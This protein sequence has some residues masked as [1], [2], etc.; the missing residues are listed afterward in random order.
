MLRKLRLPLCVL[1]LGAFFFAGGAAAQGNFE[2]QVYDS[3]TVAPGKLM[4]ELHSN[5]AVRGTTQKTEGVLPTQHALH[6]TLEMT[7][8]L[9]SWFET[10]FYFFASVQPGMAW[11]WVG[12]HV[13]PKIRVPENWDWPVGVALSAEFGYQQRKFSTDTWTVEIRPIIDKKIGRWYLALN[14]VLGRSLKGENAKRGLDFN[15]SLKVSYD[16]TSKITG[17]I[18]YYGAFGPITGFD[19]LK[20]QQHQL[21]PVVDLNLGP[22]WEFNFGVGAGL[23]SSTD[24]FIVKM[25]LGRRF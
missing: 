15:P 22:E 1:M 6:E 2:I 24:R 23:T 12:D 14:P 13:R 10:A 20:N 8:G 19:S 21:F 7:Y 4:V 25:I 18:E 11:Q 17:G 3:E 16:F 9:T 5:M